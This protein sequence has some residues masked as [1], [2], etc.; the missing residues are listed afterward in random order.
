[1][2]DR[3]YVAFT[4]RNLSNCG[5]QG[6][7]Y[8]RGCQKQLRFVMEK[9]RQGARKKRG[10]SRRGM[11]NSRANEAPSLVQRCISRSGLRRRSQ[12][13]MLT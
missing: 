13:R 2:Y 7:L 12:I 3:A 8:G 6:M 4:E 10:G 9:S 1:M 11:R 5:A